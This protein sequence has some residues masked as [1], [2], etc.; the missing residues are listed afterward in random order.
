MS[1]LI[2]A[3][4]VLAIGAAACGPSDPAITGDCNDPENLKVDPNNC[5]FCGNVCGTNTSCTNGQCVPD[6]CNPGDTRACYDGSSGTEGVGPCHGGTQ[7]CQ[8]QGYWG[9]CD[10]EALPA[11]E[12]CGNGVDENCSGTADEDTDLDGDGYTTCGGDCCDSTECASPKLVNPGAFEA[13]GNGV[14]DDCDGAVDNA[15]VG[16]CDQGIASN[17]TTAMDFAR[18]MDLCQTATLSEKKW[19]VI[20]AKFTLADG[21]GTPDAQG[22]A[23][24]DR[25]GTNLIPKAGSALAVLSTGTAADE[26]DQN[27]AYAGSVSTGHGFLETSPFPSDWLQSNGG[28]LPNAPGCPDPSGADANDPVMLTLKIRVPSNAKSFSVDSNFYSWEFPEYTCSPYNDF[29]VM[30]LDST[31][32]SSP[33]NPTDKNLAFYEDA[34]MKRWPVGVNLAANNTGLFTQCV[35]GATGC[36]VLS[37]AVPGSISTCTGTDQ[38][39]GTGFQTAASGSCDNNA[40]A[41][42]ATGWLTTRGNVVG[43]EVITLR[44]AIWDTSDSLLDSTVILDNFQW[45]VE[46]SDPGTVVN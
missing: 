16:N 7:T 44:L 41:G 33:A 19:G 15:V 32:T 2:F 17:T 45:S 39:A 20:E 10:G 9:T 12:V 8:P 3:S 25:W 13:A 37:G 5:G 27:P 1:K 36:E 14:D 11:P 43:G 28:N 34:Q 38:L 40:L 35:N 46:S 22:H 21:T 6:A 18:A 23:V 26:N 42:G 24:R 30:L 4:L 31:W 29:F